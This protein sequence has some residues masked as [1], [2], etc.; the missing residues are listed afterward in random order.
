Q[1][2]MRELGLDTD[3][4]FYRERLS[5][6]AADGTLGLR[7]LPLPAPLHL[8]GGVLAANCLSLKERISLIRLTAALRLHG[9]KTTPSLSVGQWLEQG[10]QSP[11]AIRNFWQPLCLAA[12]NTPIADACAQL[13]AHVLR[14]SLGG[15]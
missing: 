9:W 7:T 11:H 8:L 1:A 10:G 14:D 3:R 5:L 12:L 4:L 6:Q 2:V 15:P 13:F